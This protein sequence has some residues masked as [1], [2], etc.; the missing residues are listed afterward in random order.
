MNIV[1]LNEE[2]NID[3]LIFLLYDDEV[4]H[5]IVALHDDEVRDD[6]LN[7]VEYH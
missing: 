3:A 5:G 2:L 4:E 7:V 6:L 1:Y